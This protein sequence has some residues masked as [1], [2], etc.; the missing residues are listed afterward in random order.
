MQKNFFK[1]FLTSFILSMFLFAQ[2]SFAQLTGTKTIPGDYA[3][4]TAAVTDLNT[5]GVG[6]GGVTFNVAAG[7]TES[8]TADIIITATG[9]AG[10]AIIFQKSGAGANPLITRTDAGTNATSTLGGLGD[11]IIRLDGTDYITFDGIDVSAADQGIEYGYL[12]HKPDGTNGCQFVTIKNAVVTMT[13][14]TSG[15]VVGIY[16]GNGASTVSSATG[17]TVT[18]ASGI[19]SDITI[20]GNTIQN[21]HTGIV[22]RGSSATGFSDNNVVIGQSG[23]GNI[24]QNFGGGSA[25]TTYAVY[26]IYVSNPSVAYNTITSADHGSTLY[27]IF[28]SSG[29]TGNVV[30]SNNAFTL[31]NIAASSVTQ[32]IYSSNTV[33]SNNF[34]NNTFAAGTISSTGT[35][36]LI[37]ASS[38]TPDVTV[39]GNSI[40]GTITKAGG[41]TY[42]YYNFG[43]PAS[44]TE[45]ITNNNFSNI[46]VS[47]GS[48]GLYGIYTN[49]AIGSNR[50]CNNNTVSNLNHLGTGAIYGIYAL[51]T[52]SNQVNNNNVFDLTTGGTVYGLYF[53]GTNP[54]V[55]NNNVY[56]LNNF[57][58]HSLWYLRCR[59]WNN[60]LL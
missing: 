55:Y 13:K 50:V 12:T 19:N 40:V 22:S 8:T 43:S 60:K 48:S 56:N 53:T 42:C 49:T 29:I 59:F 35:V 32:Y 31:A 14:G 18:A 11:A 34:S 9:S 7:Y 57:R 1:Y 2:T 54:T 41:T 15:Y 38:S 28:Y 3:T 45:T 4:I 39:S 25:T 6:S 26:F 47:T 44:G 58:N 24:I 5:Q 17:V 37:Y 20:T 27:G 10:N 23:A 52:T 33:T 21:V 16:I 36:Y 30:G 46:T 51:S